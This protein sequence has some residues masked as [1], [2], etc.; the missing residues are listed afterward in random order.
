MN[1]DDPMTAERM[2]DL[3]KHFYHMGYMRDQGGGI[4]VRVPEKNIIYCSPTMVQKEQW[5]ESDLFVVNEADG[6]FINRPKYGNK[7]PSSPMNLI[8]ETGANC[9]VH[10][11][12]KF[13]VLLTKLIQGN[14]FSISDQEMQ[15]GITNRNNGNKFFANVDT[16]TIPIIEAEAN[17]ALLG[18]PLKRALANYPETS[19][20]L[21]RGHGV[22]C[23]GFNISW[24]RTK[25]MLECYEYLFEI[26]CE[27]M[28]CGVPLVRQ[29]VQK[30]KR[31]VS[32]SQNGGLAIEQQQ[33][34]PVVT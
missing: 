21:V 3:V 34:Q 30:Q 11:H 28:R 22:F 20:V 6:T 25:M 17:E 1:K 8:K 19:A 7:T 9:V 10:T 15:V 24:Q 12:S 18:P 5:D 26:A 23:F 14:E 29:P 33:Q 16:L 13:A 4:A 32:Q 31:R 27:M 2:V